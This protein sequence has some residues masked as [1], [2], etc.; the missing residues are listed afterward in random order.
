MFNRLMNGRNTSL[1]EAYC[2]F[3]ATV[4]FFLN[5]FLVRKL[6]YLFMLALVI[7]GILKHF[8]GGNATT[9]EA[10]FL[11]IG[12]ILSIGSLITFVLDHGFVL[13]LLISFFLLSP[14]LF[15]FPVLSVVLDCVVWG[16]GIKFLSLKRCSV[17]CTPF[18]PLCEPFSCVHVHIQCSFYD[19]DVYVLVFLQTLEWTPHRHVHFM[20][21]TCTSSSPLHPQ[22]LE[23]TGAVRGVDYSHHVVSSVPL[24]HSL[25]WL[26]DWPPLQGAVHPQWTNLRHRAC[27][28]QDHTGNFG[29]ESHSVHV[30]AA[31][32]AVYQQWSEQ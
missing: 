12:V 14:L 21:V 10:W 15:L 19:G 7:M 32:A 25:S 28:L 18:F 27:Q 9:S 4:G 22:T 8:I 23:R 1:A 29:G 11:I 2:Q 31:C 30:L 17:C 6:T 5:H 13:P 16:N 20:I 3:H 24:A 26:R